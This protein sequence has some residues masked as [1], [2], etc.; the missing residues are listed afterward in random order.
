[1]NIFIAGEGEVGE[2]L[3][4]MLTGRDHNITFISSNKE[5]ID[6]L[7]NRYD[8]LTINGNPTSI[9]T[10]RDAEIKNADLVISV[11][12]DE[13]TNLITCMLAK[14]LGAKKVI[15]RIN[16]IEYLEEKNLNMF[17][18][19]GIDSIVCP[20]R[21]AADECIDLI[22]EAGATEVYDFDGGKLSL[23]VFQLHSRAKIVGKT[24]D[25]VVGKD[26]IN[27]IKI[28][29]LCRDG[30]ASVPEGKETLKENDY[31]YTLAKP[32]GKET[33]MDA[34]GNS[35]RQ[36]RN[37]MI[38][39]GGRVAQMVA[40]GLSG[41]NIT[42]IEQN[43]EICNQIAS[44]LGNHVLCIHGDARN[45][46]LLVEEDIRDMD[47]F[48]AISDDSETNIMTG[49]LAKRL[50]VDK[51]I[52]LMDNVEYIDLAQ[53]FGIDSIINKNLITASY[54]TRF[55][56]SGDVSDIKFLN[57]IDGEI[58]EI[59]AKRGSMVTKRTIGNLP[60][61]LGV[62]FGGIIRGYESHIASPDFQIREDDK[63][64]VFCLEGTVERI[65]NLFNKRLI[66]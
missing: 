47:A 35:G 31:I 18:N 27:D 34:T 65:I 51:V 14:Q 15:S 37:I 49:L 60:L 11:F 28:L 43:A 9:H 1:M 64:I 10:L 24:I 5:F 38:V 29:A 59:K 8:L 63:A 23:Q 41:I 57:G 32:K 44:K 52:A 55:T 6:A 4:K 45:A 48:I 50:G 7:D 21:I 53:R 2:Y 56:F 12:H 25:E 13:K 33:M 3:A 17:T 26:T 19:L 30:L 66:F 54:M 20:E 16:S 46:D 39:G 42:I 62:V 61:P 40:R 22:S 58:I 36:I